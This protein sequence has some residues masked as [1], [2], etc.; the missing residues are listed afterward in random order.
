MLSKSERTGNR[1]S[2]VQARLLQLHLTKLTVVSLVQKAASLE[3]WTS[4]VGFN[5]AHDDELVVCAVHEDGLYQRKFNTRRPMVGVDCMRLDR[6]YDELIE[7]DEV[8]VD[9]VSQLAFVC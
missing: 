3:D 9:Q 8:L 6:P 7:L 4:T 2:W 1:D 5:I